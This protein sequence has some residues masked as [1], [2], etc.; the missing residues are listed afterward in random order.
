MKAAAA[1]LHQGG[2]KAVVLWDDPRPVRSPDF[3]RAL[4]RAIHELGGRY[5]AAEDVGA[6]TADMDG[7]ADGDALGHRR[8]RVRR[9]IG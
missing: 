5:L 2:G 3:L 1:G 7:I 8:Q 6:T 9:W 4:G